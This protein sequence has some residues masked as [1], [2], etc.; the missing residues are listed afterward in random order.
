VV[1]PWGTQAIRSFF[2]I[3]S[4]SPYT[5]KP[6]AKPSTQPRHVA[7]RWM[8]AAS[9]FP[10][11][12]TPPLLS[13]LAQ[14]SRKSRPDLLISGCPGVL[15]WEVLAGE[16]TKKI[17]ISAGTKS[18]RTVAS[19]RRMLENECT[20][21]PVSLVSVAAKG[22]SQAVSLLF[23]TPAG[24]SIRVAAKGLRR[25]RGWGRGDLLLR[26]APVQSLRLRPGEK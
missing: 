25:S 16:H 17:L 18:R 21:H 26:L 3:L 20:P 19:N 8:R 1:T 7:S 13:T 2:G 22:F 15:F 4:S 23:A 24:R 10:S 12:S 9:L 14:T 5:R 6:S 11:L